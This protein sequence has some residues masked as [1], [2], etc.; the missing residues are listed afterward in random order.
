MTEKKEPRTERERQLLRRE[1]LMVYLPMIL[2]ALLVLTLVILIAVL[3][4]KQENLAGDPAS[5]WGD[6]TAI[7]VLIQ[8]MLISLFPLIL[9]VALCVLLFW[10]FIK[11]QPILQRIQEIVGMVQEKVD[12]AGDKVTGSLTKPYSTAARIRAFSQFIRRSNV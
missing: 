9:L 2:G 7:I 11:V 6:A 1:W 3:G 12:Q 4:L 10:L 5:A 8:V